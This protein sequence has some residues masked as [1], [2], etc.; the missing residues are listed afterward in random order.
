MSD[1]VWFGLRRFGA[2]LVRLLG[3]VRC[4]IV[5]IFLAW[6][7]PAE[8]GIRQAACVCVCFFCGVSGIFAAWYGL[9]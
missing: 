6:G 7:K 5:W 2:G 8:G 3:L 1:E 4:S 9:G